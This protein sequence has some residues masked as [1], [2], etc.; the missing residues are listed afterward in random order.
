MIQVKNYLFQKATYA[1]LRQPLA[2]PAHIGTILRT[3]R[4]PDVA[5]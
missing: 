4:V 1:R 5:T 3:N 2:E